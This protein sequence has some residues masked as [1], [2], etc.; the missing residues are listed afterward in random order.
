MY[1]FVSADTPE[2]LNEVYRIRYQVY[3]VEN[4]FEDPALNPGG[5]ERDEYDDHSV[6]G[7]LLDRVS[8]AA[9]GT[10]RVIMHK[11]GARPG[12]LPFHK[13]CQADLHRADLLPYRTTAEFSR[14]AISKQLRRG[15]KG[16]TGTSIEAP[17][18]GGHIAIPHITVGLITAALRLCFAN[19]VTHACAVMEPTLLRLLSRF[20]IHFEPLG[21]QVPYHGWRQPCFAKLATLMAGIEQE[22]RDVWDAVT[23]R[24]R[25]WSPTPHASP[26]IVEPI[27]A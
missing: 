8:K 23:E 17:G 4:Q 19:R 15:A 22:R 6:H 25:L 11:P 10:V 1:Q 27:V 16:R 2:L 9:V 18:V 26:D 3:C 24:G 13:V 20:G 12:S 21:P 7:L 14:F 5:I